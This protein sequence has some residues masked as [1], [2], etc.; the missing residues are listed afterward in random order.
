MLRVWNLLIKSSTLHLGNFYKISLAINTCLKLQ[1][2]NFKLQNQTSSKFGSLKQT[3]F[4]NASVGLKNFIVNLVQEYGMLKSSNSALNQSFSQKVKKRC[5]NFSRH[6]TLISVSWLA[7][8]FRSSIFFMFQVSILSTNACPHH[9][10]SKSI[11]KQVHF[12]NQ[13]CK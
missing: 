13:S 2:F 11:S 12:P 9:H 5:F 1:Q 4:I 3:L 8:N 10:Q 7:D 6:F